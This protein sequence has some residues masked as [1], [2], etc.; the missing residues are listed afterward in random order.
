MPRRPSPPSPPP[1]PIGINL[2]RAEGSSPF[3]NRL[4]PRGRKRR[5]TREVN[6]YATRFGPRR[7]ELCE[8]GNEPA[9]GGNEQLLRRIERVDPSPCSMETS[10]ARWRPLPARWR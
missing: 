4:P 1:S 5:G 9:E 3:P 8:R 6:A 2:R 10:N 7:H